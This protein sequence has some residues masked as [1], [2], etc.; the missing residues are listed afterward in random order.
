MTSHRH[1]GSGYAQF[2]AMEL[3]SWST[4]KQPIVH[5]Q[6]LRRY[7]ALTHASK[8]VLWIQK[9]FSELHLRQVSVPMTFIATTRVQSGSQ[10]IHIPWTYKAI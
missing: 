7:V 5:S 8:D 9:L 6:A 4:K 2:C 3:V 10:K 1:S